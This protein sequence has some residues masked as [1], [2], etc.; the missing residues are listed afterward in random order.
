MTDHRLAD[1]L[2]AKAAQYENPDFIAGDPISVPHLF[3]KQ[4]D[5]E[6][7]GFFAA[8]FAWGHRR[9]IINK[10]TQLM[11]LMDNRPYEFVMNASAPELLRLEGFAHRTFNT[12]DVLYFIEFFRSHY[13]KFHSLENA[14]VPQVKYQQPNVEEA[15][16]HFYGKIFSLNYVL[17]RTRKHISAPFKKSTCKRLCMYLRWMVRSN[18]LGVD[19][20]IWKNINPA[21][22]IIPLDL[23]VTNVAFGLKMI[24]DRKVNWNTALQLTETLKGMDPKDPAKYDFALFSL[25]EAERF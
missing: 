8:I 11:Q 18:A 15:L 16:N 19:F 10:A 4:Q 7:A 9:I 24:S 1:F 2:N 23:H 21:Q 13:N 3:T 14:F 12:T 20:G 25:G 5:I 6:I 17:G 22:L